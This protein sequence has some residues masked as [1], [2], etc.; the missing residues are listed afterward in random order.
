MNNNDIEL[1]YNNFIESFPPF[2]NEYI[3]K[4]LLKV[5]F[6]ELCN[7]I[8]N[9]DP[10]ILKKL[11]HNTEIPNEVCDKLLIT[12]GA[13]QTLISSLNNWDKIQ[14]LE[15][16]SDIFF[17]YKGT[18]YSLIKILQTYN[19]NISAYELYLD[20]N[21][22]NKHW[23]FKPKCIY[24]NEANSIIDYELSFDEINNAIPTFL[25]NQYYLDNL[26][27]NNDIIL[28]LKTNLLL[29]DYG[30]FSETSIM[31]D[32]MVSAFLKEY[33]DYTIEF[34]LNLTFFD[35]SIS[36]ITSLWFYLV[37]VYFDYTWLPFN[38]QFM[39]HYDKNNFLNIQDIETIINELSNLDLDSSTNR[40]DMDNFFSMYLH[41]NF[42]NYRQVNLPV[43][44]ENLRTF[45]YNINRELILFID[46]QIKEKENISKLLAELYYILERHIN[47]NTNNL[48]KKYGIRWLLYLPQ[49]INNITQTPEYKLI[50]EIKPYHVDLVKNELSGVTIDDK[51]NSMTMNSNGLAFIDCN[52]TSSFVIY[53]TYEFE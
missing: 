18:I 12:I 7:N 50:N 28:P 53:D 35:L 31:N 21:K 40:S 46:E 16:L 1:Y 43:T 32:L 5:V 8:Y 13:S 3:Y 2:K 6:K 9:D 36:T 10:I 42:F 26:N 34:S 45:L 30:N 44:L 33:E 14:L 25:L 22:I 51:F 19:N 4:S 27:T 39:L 24:N 47:N 29:L 11:F 49:L 37:S 23:I 38:R 15:N 20:Y 52:Y 48:F 41:N 17:K